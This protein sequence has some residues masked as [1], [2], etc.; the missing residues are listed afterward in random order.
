[1]AEA[2]WGMTT[3]FRKMEVLSSAAAFEDGAV[4]SWSKECQPVI[5]NNLRTGKIA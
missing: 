3:V 4:G 2:Y 5:V 1:M